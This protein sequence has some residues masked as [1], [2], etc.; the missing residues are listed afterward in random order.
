MTVTQQ[1]LTIAIVVMGTMLTR[2]LPFLI[3]GS[4]KPAPEYIQSLGRILPS[5]TLGMLVVYCFKD[6]S[7]ISGTH[8]LPEMISLL[9]IVILHFWKKNMFLSII[10]G[11]VCY[12][13]LFYFL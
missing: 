2:F 7:F 1:F 6:V 8:G 5:A 9:F 12:M 3:F 10:G 13:C 11:T 4:D